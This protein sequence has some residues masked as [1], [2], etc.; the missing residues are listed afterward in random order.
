MERH[1]YAPVPLR[2]AK[3]GNSLS[4][5]LYEAGRDCRHDCILH[6]AGISVPVIT[7]WSFPSSN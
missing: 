7:A 4:G 6:E 5:G 3:G 2:P 1:S